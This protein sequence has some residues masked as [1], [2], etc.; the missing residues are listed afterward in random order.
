[1]R[2]LLGV[3][4]MLATAAFAAPIAGREVEAP[5]ATGGMVLDAWEYFAP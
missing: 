4:V 3:F 1:M 5:D 2:R